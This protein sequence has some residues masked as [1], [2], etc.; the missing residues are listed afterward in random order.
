MIDDTKRILCTINSTP[1]KRFHS[2]I[3]T[4]ADKE[5]VW[6]LESEDGYMTLDIDG[7][8]NLL[9]WPE[10]VYAKAFDENASPTYIEVHHFCDI[11][12]DY[13]HQEKIRFMVFPTK[14]DTYI[15]GVSELLD[16]ILNELHRL[17]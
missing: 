8:V 16:C 5:A 14:K 11:C 2:F 4:V 10:E 9:L 7:Y 1:E 12:R 15:I 17:E 3:S 6:L 13:I